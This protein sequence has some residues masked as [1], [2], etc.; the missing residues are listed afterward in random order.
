MS[1][2]LCPIDQT[3]DKLRLDPGLKINHFAVNKKIYSFNIALAVFVFL[4]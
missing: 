1:L 3:L 4:S 2:L